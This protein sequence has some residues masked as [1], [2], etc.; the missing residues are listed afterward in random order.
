MTTLF[1]VVA[2]KHRVSTDEVRESLGHRRAGLDV[3][4]MLP[5]AALYGLVAY[6]VSRRVCRNFPLGSGS[7]VAAAL[8]AT[9]MTSML[10]SLPA[11]MAGEMYAITVEMIRVGNGHLSYRTDRVPW[12]QHRIA[13]FLAGMVLFWLIAGLRYRTEGRRPVAPSRRWG[14]L[15]RR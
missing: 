5:F 4:I 10:V 2:R 14:H 7:D 15:A 13:L 9:V 3:A 11:V 6:G 12:T 8:V 1:E